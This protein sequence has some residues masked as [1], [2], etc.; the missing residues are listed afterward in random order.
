MG[1]N[2]GHFSDQGL[3]PSSSDQ[4]SSQRVAPATEAQNPAANPNASTKTPLAPAQ[5][6]PTLPQSSQPE[7][8]QQASPYGDLSSLHDLYTKIPTTGGGLER[9]GSDTFLL[10]TGN[11]SELPSDLPVGPDYVLGTGDILIVNIWGSES[12]RLE[13]AV[14]PQGQVSIPEAGM[15]VVTGLRIDQAQDAIQRALN[16]QF[17]SEHVEISLGRVRTVRVYV[18]GD[19]QRPGAY[20]VSSLSTPLNALYAAG[21][22]TSRGSMRILKQLRGDQVV[23]KI[24]LYDFLLKGVRSTNDRLMAGDTIVVPPAGPEVSIEG[25]VH[26]PAIYE[27]NGES[28]LAQVLDLAG[29]ASITANLKQINVSRIV[30]NQKRTMLSIEL[31]NDSS[32]ITKQLADF[33]VQGGDDVTISQ[34]LPYNNQAVYL[35]GHVYRPGK[36]PYKEGM[37]I[38]DLVH[39]YEDVLPEPSTHAELVRLTAPDYRP[40]TI[41]FN[42]QDALVGNNP[43][44]LQPF[45]LIRVFGRYEVD[46]PMVSIQGEV[47]HPG[48]YPMSQGMTAAGLVL[49][50]GGFKRSAF[51]DE[52]DLSSYDLEGGKRALISHSEVAIQ[53]AIDGDKTAD[54]QLK[55]GDVLSIRTIAGWQDIGA[56]ITLSGEVEHPGSYGIQAGEHLS[57]VLKRAGGFRRD[58]YPPAAVFERVQ[59]RQLA[60]QAK[61]QMIERIEETPVTVKSGTTNTQ[62]ESFEQQAINTDREQLLNRLRNLPASG[63]LV[64]T[65]TTDFSKWENTAADIELR[66]GDT[67]VIPKRPSFVMVSGQV[68]NPMAI[69]Y[70]PGKSL[71]FYLRKTG[72]ATPGANKKSIYV[73]RADGS[74]IPKESGWMGGNYSSTRLSPGD[75]IFVPEKIQSPSMV[76]QNIMGVAQLFTLA[77]LPIAI[78]GL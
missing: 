39:S 74:V 2:S 60:E 73:L 9:F 3:S 70:V 32:A 61:Q 29:G 45:D 72:G 69:T 37:T 8:L 41:I 56:S 63:R 17:K 50:A 10:G 22:P 25:M 65:I 52:A 78:A 59:V 71:D 11:T 67:L 7:P 38:S 58:A 64:I 46:A 42:L 51:R 48:E 33:K 24:D 77:A 68:F 53:K 19:V 34:I 40:Q 36:Y 44:L 35:E 18:V 16:T 27:L 55:P 13:R 43:I 30:A 76:W 4:N 20:D 15:V 54:V 66:A 57:S 5:P 31:P 75:T 12:G 1:G 26:R 28:T 21:G 6:K 23:R 47:L 62:T 14:D 49:M